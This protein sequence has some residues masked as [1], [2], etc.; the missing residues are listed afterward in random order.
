MPV[1]A[2]NVTQYVNDTHTLYITKSSKGSC[3]LI[4]LVSIVEFK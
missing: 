4:T 1:L 3:V 2:K